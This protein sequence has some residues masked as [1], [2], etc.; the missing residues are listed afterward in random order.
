MSVVVR[1]SAKIVYVWRN[2]FTPCN[3]RR[4]DGLPY[5]YICGVICLHHVIAGARS[6]AISVYIRRHFPSIGY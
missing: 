3:S 2:L 5:L 4:Q 6:S 1:P